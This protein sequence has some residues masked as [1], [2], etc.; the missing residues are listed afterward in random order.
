[1]AGAN[2]RHGSVHIPVTISVGV[3]ALE[4]NESLE[5]LTER[6]DQAMYAAKVKGRN[7]VVISEPK[8]PLAA[9]GA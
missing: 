7:C 3:S 9:V 2:I 4:G 5:A 6:A 1:V 8:A